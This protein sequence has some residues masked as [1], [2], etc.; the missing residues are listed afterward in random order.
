MVQKSGVT[1]GGYTSFINREPERPLV[2][3]VQNQ[4][5]AKGEER[6]AR[7]FDKSIGRGIIQ[8]Y[9]FRWTTLR[10][11]V[12]GYKELDFLV[13]SNLGPVAIS[14]KGTDFV[15]R[16]AKSKEQ[17]KINEILILSKL[18]ELGYNVPRI[19]TIPAEKLKTQK[20]ADKVARDLGLYR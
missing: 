16:N 9:K 11:G 15:H 4:K 10:R 5:A 12:V 7:T 6:L 18:R 17:D 14:V 3:K 20:E 2:G 13:Y 8:D 1:R 19:T